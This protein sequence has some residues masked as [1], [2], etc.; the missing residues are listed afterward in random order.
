MASS[1]SSDSD[2]ELNRQKLLLEIADLEASP[3]RARQTVLLTIVT[4]LLTATTTLAVTVGGWRIGAQIQQNADRQN[5]AQTYAKLLQDSGSTNAA[6]RLGSIVGLGRYAMP[7]HGDGEDR[8]EQT[9]VV[10]LGRLTA[11]DDGDVVQMIVERLSASGAPTIIPTIAAQERARQLLHDA[12]KAYGRTLAVRLCGRSGIDGDGT[13]D[14]I[15]QARLGDALRPL[16]AGFSGDTRLFLD[17]DGDWLV[18]D[19]IRGWRGFCSRTPIT[20]ISAVIVQES[21]RYDATM[22]E[23]SARGTIAMGRILGNVARRSSDDGQRPLFSGATMFDVVWTPGPN[24]RPLNLSGSEFSRTYISGDAARA[25]L[26]GARLD[27]ADLRHLGLQGAS[28]RSASLR[29]T[30]LDAD[31]LFKE[32]P[33]LDKADWWNASLTTGNPRDYVGPA[34]CHPS[35]AWLRRTYPHE[36]LNASTPCGQFW[37]H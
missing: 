6:V 5:D 20:P 12:T 23:R 9:I 15:L 1:T 8:S 3:R 28:L 11:E 21:E 2:S 30:R 16:G 33:N 32:R 29:S 7:P 31:R 37:K 4:A 34:S 14:Y 35:V 18:G 26:D 10:L 17:A 25:V 19:T 24:G 27:F 36:S 22:M 13:I